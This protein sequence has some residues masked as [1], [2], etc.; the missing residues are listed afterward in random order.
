MKDDKKLILKCLVGSRA[1]GLHT[2]E[3]DFD[4]RGVYVEPTQ[5]ILSLGYKYKGSGWFEGKEDQTMYEIGHFLHLALKCNPSILEVFM[6][7]RVRRRNE[8]YG[9]ELRRNFDFG[10]DLCRLFPYIWNPKN[11]F[12]AFVGYGLNQRKKMLDKKDSRPRKYAVAYLRT[13]WNLYD[14]L[15]T[16]KFNLKVT[17][18]DF[19]KELEEIKYS[20]GPLDLGY[21]IN[22]AESLTAHAEGVLPL[23][24]HK[25]EPEKVNQ[26]L[27][28]IR[29]E[30]WLCRK[31]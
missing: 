4:Y 16:G 6:A 31:Y 24:Q 19:R 10:S 23:C 20:T 17:D 15:V 2:L 3:S 21:V 13:L 12:D 8:L 27:L 9:E 7:P 1:H 14:L 25:A 22:R 29:K 30:Y 26:F 18:P 5:K 11:A 28:K